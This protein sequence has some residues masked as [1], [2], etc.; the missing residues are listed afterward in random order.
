[1]HRSF[2]TWAIALVL[3][4]G[5]ISGAAAEAGSKM[6]GFLKD[7]YASNPKACVTNAYGESE[8]SGLT[9]KDG[10]IYGTEFSCQFLSYTPVKWAATDEI[11]EYVAMASCG[12]DSGITRPDLISIQHYEGT[13]RLQS[14]NEY[15]V[16]MAKEAWNEPGFIS[17]NYE[18]CA[19][20]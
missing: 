19:A 14:Q 12:D 18:K 7:T 4:A 3:A 2:V 20:E 6:P 9:I 10:A 1:M 15:V 16:M 11:N 13:L 17:V 5:G 8:A